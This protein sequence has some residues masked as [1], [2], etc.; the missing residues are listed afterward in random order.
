MKILI[1]YNYREHTFSNPLL[2][3]HP[4]QC[5]I[6]DC[7]MTENSKG[8]RGQIRQFTFSRVALNKTDKRLKLST[9]SQSIFREK[10]KVIL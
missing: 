4:V 1:P 7:Q 2:S 3:K 6:S 9:Y 5:A 10:M 8:S